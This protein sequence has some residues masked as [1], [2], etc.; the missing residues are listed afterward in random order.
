MTKSVNVWDYKPKWC[1]PWSILLTGILIIFGSW[2]LLKILWL[3]LGISL[4]IVVWWVYFLILYP[5]MMKEE[6][7]KIINE[8]Y[9]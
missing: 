7:L 5:Q 2:L 4:L 3:T 1:Q 8:D 6:L 9:S